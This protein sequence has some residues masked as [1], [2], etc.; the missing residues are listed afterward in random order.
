[1][2]AGDVASRN[3]F[4]KL[5]LAGCCACALRGQYPA[6]DR[7]A[8]PAAYAITANISLGSQYLFRG[9]SQTDRRPALQGGFDYAHRA[10]FYVGIWGSNVS[11]I[12]DANPDAS[13]S[14]E[15]DAYLG[16]RK[17][18]ARD[19]TFDIGYIH[20]RFPGAY[21]ESLIRP[22]TDELYGALSWRVFTLKYSHARGDFFGL[23]HARH[24]SYLEG[25]VAATLP[26]NLTLNLHAGRQAYRSQA[27]HPTNE[28]YSYSDW[29]AELVWASSTNWFVGAGY[30]AT[31]ARKAFYTPP[32]TGRFIGAGQAYGFLKK[33]L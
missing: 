13:L 30:S 3:G 10:G 20:Y 11:W 31:N 26:G 2:G 24:T 33:I 22:D 7:A 29:R 17:P 18:F 6:A 9:L 12:V 1:M 25:S 27:N 19:W 32:A 23:P 8:S 4:L 14:L 15:L 16:F 21:P 28:P 5:A